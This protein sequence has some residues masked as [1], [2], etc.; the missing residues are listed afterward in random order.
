MFE[1]SGSDRLRQIAEGSELER[2]HRRVHGRLTGHEDDGD[3]Q[4]L[5]SDSVQERDTVHA[6]HRKV[7]KDKVDIVVGGESFDDA[8]EASGFADDSLRVLPRDGLTQRVAKQRM[9]VR[10]QEPVRPRARHVPFLPDPACFP[11]GF[12]RCAPII[13]ARDDIRK[14]RNA[15]GRSRKCESPW[16]SAFIRKSNSGLRWL[17]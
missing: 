12:V 3:V 7:E 2:L 10:D 5:L 6:G 14:Q 17:C 11:G 13:R 16:C 1:L 9:V 4:V 8:L 15:A